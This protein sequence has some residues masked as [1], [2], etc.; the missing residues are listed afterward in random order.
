MTIQEAA[1][2]AGWSPRMLRYL[3]S[4]GLAT[5]QRT[6][7]GY[8]IYSPEQVRCLRSLR[9][10]SERHE[11]DL[12]DAGFALRLRDD[13]FLRHS[14]NELLGLLAPPERITPAASGTAW[15]QFEQAKHQRLLQITDTTATNKEIA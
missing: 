4:L 5:P 13:P 2:E 9:E 8:R 14:L 11:I 6:P 7:S 15:L 12:R 10:L 1:E 3:E